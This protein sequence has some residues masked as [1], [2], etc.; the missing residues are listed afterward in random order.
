MPLKPCIECGTITNQA[1]CPNHQ[2]GDYG[3]QHQQEREAWK[4]LVDAGNV[5]CRRAPYGLCV[6]DDPRIHPGEPWHLGHPDH[7]C[8]AP[9]APEHVVCNSGA[10]RRR[11]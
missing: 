10:P 3:W 8:P 2:L 1:R 5:E 6:A 11:T 4:P 9:K 7:A